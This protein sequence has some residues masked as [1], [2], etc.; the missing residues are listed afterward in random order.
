MK[1]DTGRGVQKAKLI[2]SF[3]FYLATVNNSI[4]QKLMAFKIFKNLPYSWCE[5]KRSPLYKTM[6]LKENNMSR[7]VY[8]G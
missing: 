8:V 3:L 7:I 5:T 6:K 1:T 2:N 4:T